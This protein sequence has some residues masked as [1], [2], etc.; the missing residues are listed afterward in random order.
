M[1]TEE[2]PYIKSTIIKPRTLCWVLACLHLGCQ[3]TT[4][5]T[6]L[7]SGHIDPY[8]AWA[9]TIYL[10]KIPGYATLF[11]GYDGLIVDSATIAPDGAFAFSVYV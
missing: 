1:S 2:I 3:A 6:A 8:P 7:L 4:A 5:Q 11:S 9:Q 10:C